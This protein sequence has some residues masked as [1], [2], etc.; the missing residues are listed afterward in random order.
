[1]RWKIS[2]EP[3]NAAAIAA[4][5]NISKITA[6][7]LA[8]RGMT[9][10][11]Q[12]RQYLDTSS[13]NLLDVRDIADFYKG[14]DILKTS[15]ENNKKIYVYGDYDA[16]GVMSTTIL[17]KGLQTLGADVHYY[18]PHRVYDGYGLNIAAVEKIH[19]N[20]CEL[21]IT[22]DNGIASLNEVKR[23]KQ[24]GMSVIILDHH[25]PVC[26]NGVQILPEA[27]AVI[28]CKR[29]DSAF[30]FREMCAA[31]LCYRF[32]K[33]FFIYTQKP[34]GLDRELVTFAGIATV[35]D[36]VPLQSDNRIFVK[37]A[38]Y[39]INKD[40]RNMGLKQLTELTCSPGSSV[41]SYT[42]GFIIGPCINAIG[43]LE[44]ASEA[45]ELFLTEDSEKAKDYAVK[46][47]Q[48]NKERKDITLK[49]TELLEKQVDASL[50]IQV[51]Y[52]PT[53]HESV[54]G[55]IAGQIKE[56]FN[57]PTLVITNAED[58]CKGSG[59]SI[60]EYDLVK[61]LALNKRFF[62]KFGGHAL[63][64]GFSL[65]KENIDPLRKA[66]NE[67]CTL[68]EQ[69]LIPAVRLDCGIKLEEL[70]LET[71]RELM[72]LEPFGQGN[73]RPNFFSLGV[74]LNSLQLAGKDRQT[75]QYTFLTKNDRRIKGVSFKAADKICTFLA[76]QGKPELAAMLENGNTVKMNMT[77][78][79]AYSLDINTYNGIESL[80]LMII[81]IR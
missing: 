18:V 52:E 5:N 62:T 71:V 28:D 64:A 33:S 41:T 78:D 49:A 70:K 51:L 20:G 79:I 66:L 50:P 12:I 10:P 39:L 34:F 19:K 35:C 76:E 27:D 74:T 80:Q 30:A 45:V 3:T 25:E 68:T 44:S 53:V 46:L 24:L 55:I 59:R 2:D 73:P 69:Q 54:A 9:T 1:M 72:L 77:A 48:K 63:A 31:G 37:L 47:V 17:C 21:L 8:N 4:E 43:R 42:L 13:K 23:A 7:V 81:D 14:M 57:R 67:S 40:L 58:G 6:V 29:K 32:I 15:I 60:E 11:A 56:K 22:C 38:L 16:D 75:V 26:E 61:N 36:I 65:P